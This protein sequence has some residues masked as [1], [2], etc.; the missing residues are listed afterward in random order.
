MDGKR[1]SKETVMLACLD[2]D[3]DDDD[4][5]DNLGSLIILEM[6]YSN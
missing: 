6:N 3:D 2:D 4:D 1:E 5:D